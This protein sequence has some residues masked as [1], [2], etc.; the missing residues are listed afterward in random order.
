MMGEIEGRLLRLGCPK[1]N[2]Q[3]RAGN[4]RVASFYERLGYTPDGASGF[5]KRLVP[6]G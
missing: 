2:V 6:D 1:V 4:D 3:V 5:G